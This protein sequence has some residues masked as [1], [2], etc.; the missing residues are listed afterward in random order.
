MTIRRQLFSV[1]LLLLIWAVLPPGGHCGAGLPPR[2]VEGVMDLTAWDFDGNRTIR[3]GT[4]E[5]VEGRRARQTMLD[6]FLL[7]AIAIMGLYHLGLFLLRIQE[8]PSLWF[9]VFCFLIVFRFLATGERNLMSMAPGLSWETRIK[10]EYLAYYLAVPAFLLRWVFSSLFF[11][12]RFF[13]PAGF[14]VRYHQQH[15]G[16]FQDRSRQTRNRSH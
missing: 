10:A 5:A 3:L 7:G 2:A 14:P 4:R 1:L 6:F 16:L 12:W 9:G 11:H 8:K 15:P 13:S